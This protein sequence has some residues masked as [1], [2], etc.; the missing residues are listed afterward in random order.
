MNSKNKNAYECLC[1]ERRAVSRWICF[2]LLFFCLYI[3]GLTYGV[4]YM[5]M[6]DRIIVKDSANNFF[7]GN[8]EP[9]SSRKVI[10]LLSYKAAY[11]FLNRSYDGKNK[12]KLALYFSKKGMKTVN[13][14]LSRDAKFF[15]ERKIVQHVKI[16]R[17]RCIKSGYNEYKACLQGHL[18]KNGFY[19]GHKYNN[20]VEFSLIFI[21][22]K[23]TIAKRLPLEITK[24]KLGEWEP[25]EN[26]N[27][28]RKK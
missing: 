5:N 14:Y 1:G 10:S 8:S 18:F 23:G 16:E 19:F 24:L 9:L 20:K 26:N 3:V 11:A 6:P 13:A 15:K 25:E 27:N 7:V 4:K 21:I 2:Y 17:F 28:D 22:K 12:K